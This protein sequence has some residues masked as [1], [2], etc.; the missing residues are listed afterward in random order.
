MLN[1]LTQEQIWQY[2]ANMDACRGLGAQCHRDGYDIHT[3]I[4][5]MARKGF[6]AD[7]VFAACQG[8]ERE[9]IDTTSYDE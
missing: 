3:M 9:E 4:E 7:A 5:D 8:W 1:H 2:N 6:S